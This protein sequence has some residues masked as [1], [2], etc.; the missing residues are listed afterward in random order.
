MY[1]NTGEEVIVRLSLQQPPWGGN[2]GHNVITRGQQT[3]CYIAVGGELLYSIIVVPFVLFV[4][5]NERFLPIKCG[6]DL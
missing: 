1:L 3:H 2:L 6:V 5:A 4:Q